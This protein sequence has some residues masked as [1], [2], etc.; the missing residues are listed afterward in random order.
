MALRHQIASWSASWVRPGRGSARGDRAF[1]ATLLHRLRPGEFDRLRLLVRPET[2]LR[3]RVPRVYL[4]A[5]LAA[6][7]PIRQYQAVTALPGLLPPSPAIPGS[8][9]PQLHPP[10]RR[11]GDEGL[12]PPS[13]QQHLVAHA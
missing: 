5:S 8:G 6:P 13:K 2:V 10:L 11:Q 1:P 9:C 3:R 12:P 7:R 4:P